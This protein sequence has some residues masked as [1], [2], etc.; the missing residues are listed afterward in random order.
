MRDEALVKTF[1]QQ[2]VIFAGVEPCQQPGECGK[3]QSQCIHKNRHFALLWIGEPS[4]QDGSW[5]RQKRNTHQK[6]NIQEQEH[7]VGAFI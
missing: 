3:E 1:V 7:L 6:Q 2:P 4:R 5:K